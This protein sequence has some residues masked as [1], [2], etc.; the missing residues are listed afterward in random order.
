MK[1]HLLGMNW[2]NSIPFNSFIRNN[3]NKNNNNKYNTIIKQISEKYAIL[4]L[5]ALHRIIN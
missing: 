1:K 2:Y 4:T 5:N 3:N